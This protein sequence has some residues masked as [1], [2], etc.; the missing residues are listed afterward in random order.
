[1]TLIGASVADIT[2]VVEVGPPTEKN[3]PQDE[4][5]PGGE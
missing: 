1:M 3:R 2:I 4:T 5:G